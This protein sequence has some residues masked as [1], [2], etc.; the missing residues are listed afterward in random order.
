M[1]NETP[2]IVQ[3]SIVKVTN[4][5]PADLANVFL[6]SSDWLAQY[7]PNLMFS[8][9]TAAF[10]TEQLHCIVNQMRETH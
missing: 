2:I 6:S 1:T 10:Y 3:E 4:Q 8:H 5:E 7:S 9:A